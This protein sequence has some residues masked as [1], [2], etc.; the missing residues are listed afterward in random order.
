MATSILDR[1]VGASA[2]V[3]DIERIGS[4][5]AGAALILGGLR[6][7]GVTGR[8]AMA[9]G[10]AL[11][12]RG[13]TGY[14]PAYAQMER[15][16]TLSRSA[17]RIVE[18]FQVAVPPVE[19]YA[20]WR[21]L[22]R[23]P[24]FMKHLKSVTVDGA[25]SHWAARFAG[26]PVVEWDAELV[27]DVPGKVISWRSVPS[28]TGLENSGSVTFVDLG[29]RGTGV[30]VEIGYYPPAGPIGR[31]LGRLF[32]SVTEQQVRADVRRFKSLLEAGEVPSTEGQSRAVA[33]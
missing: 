20:A 10:S 4:T 33:R 23:L 9:V 32:N 24:R 11:M 6:R 5:L 22:T 3:G 19:A 14:C 8:G 15:R 17:I 25:F 13:A 12:A 2:N 21:D 31:S 28:S 7:G 18:T 30:R 27:R 16:R 1:R 29:A 26:L